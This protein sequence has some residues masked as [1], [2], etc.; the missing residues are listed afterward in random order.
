LQRNEARAIAQ[1]VRETELIPSP[2][3][4]GVAV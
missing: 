3:V 1:T 2:K 4:T